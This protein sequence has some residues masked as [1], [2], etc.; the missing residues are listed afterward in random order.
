MLECLDTADVSKA[1]EIWASEMAH[2][3]QALTYAEAE[4]TLHYARTDCRSLRFWKRAYS[5]A[6]LTERGLPS[7]LPDDLRPLAHRL[8]PRVAE[9]VGIATYTRTPKALEVRGAMEAAVMECF[10]DK[11]TSPDFIRA[12]MFEVRDRILKKW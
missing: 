1:W 2:L 8:Y 10:E 4:Q 7:G 6:W 3:P 12:R 9:G 5:H 11:K